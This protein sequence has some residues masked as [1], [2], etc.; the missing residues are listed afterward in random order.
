MLTSAA[1]PVSEANYRIPSNT[2]RQRKDIRRHSKKNLRSV[3]GAS[4]RNWRRESRRG[5][6]W[7]RPALA[8]LQTTV[9]GTVVASRAVAFPRKGGPCAETP[10]GHAWTPETGTVVAGDPAAQTLARPATENCDRNCS[11]Q[12]PRGLALCQACCQGPHAET[13]VASRALSATLARPVAAH[14]DR[15]CSRGWHRRQGPRQARYK[16]LRPELS[17]PL[18]PWPRPLPSRVQRPENGTL[19]ASPTIHP[20]KSIGTHHHPAGQG[21]AGQGR[22][23]HVHRQ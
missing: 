18:A 22:A 15:N 3:P 9:T 20:W 21:R 1:G 5:P 14:C 17:S 11:C 13:V 8:P 6:S 16:A 10:Q 12:S 23:W 19:V 4:D 2:Q 7:P